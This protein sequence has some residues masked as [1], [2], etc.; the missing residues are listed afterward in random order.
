MQNRL[1][2]LI[3]SVLMVGSVFA[4]Q[5]SIS[6]RDILAELMEYTGE[7]AP[8]AEEAF[9]VGVEQTPVVNPDETPD[10]VVES[11]EESTPP[12][13]Q[14]EETS[15][16]FDGDFTDASQGLA[17]LVKIAPENLA[18]RMYIR[19]LMERDQRTAEINGME[20]VDAAW[21]MDLVLRSYDLV[22]GAA[23]RMKLG[24]ETRVVD[25]DTLF[26]QVEFPKGS[27]AIYQPKTKTLFVNN[28][29][30]NLAV[31][32]AMM[33]TMGVLKGFGD[34]DQV[35]IEAK[36][37]E[38]SEGT[39]ENLGFQWNLTEESGIGGGSGVD[40]SDGE[41]GLFAGA[42]RGSPNWGV[43]FGGDGTVFPPLPKEYG[44]L[45][46]SL[47]F[48]QAPAGDGM[49]D[50]NSSGW[51][52]F[53]FEDTFS[54]ELAVANF[55]FAGKNPIDFIIS[56]LDQST[57]SDVL[58]APRILTRSGEEATIQVGELHYYPE[59]YESDASQATIV[60]INYEDF[61]ESL[62]GVELTVT[63]V[64]TDE[65]NIS[66]EL[67]PIIRE[68]AGWHT[69]QLAPANYINNYYQEIRFGKLDHE[70]VIASLPIFKKREIKTQVTI[71]DGS[72][73]GMGG[74]IN[75]KIENYEDKVPFLG[76]LP[77]VGRLFR[78]EGERVVKRN[79]L[80]FVKA[81]IIDPNGRIDTSRS[82]E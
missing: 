32:E 43:T 61:S 50:A 16:L 74:L 19:T 77:L 41:V 78:T 38:V 79:L 48:T 73:I 60:Q 62:L 65:R 9:P 72:T 27:S 46:G 53:R 30:E 20:A 67:N 39:L 56:A 23:E 4:Q 44:H 17:D 54:D 34:A 40:V 55:K 70:P 71:A 35:E 10:A 33:E 14:F 21:S 13:E 69:Y 75:E 29:Q 57:G 51:N 58:S 42:L 5:T 68:L 12:S 15:E 8:P 36:F 64:V 3:A 11:T 25:V 47:P 37:V 31:L 18:A 6:V 22:S 1:N 49:L 80:M 76:N 81:T 24:D 7:Q 28:T 52:S 66:L 63:P 2:L 45:P 59:V 82:F 26:S